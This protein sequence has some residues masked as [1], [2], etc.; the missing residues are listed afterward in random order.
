[1]SLENF[2]IIRDARA[3]RSSSWDR[4]GGN[5]DCLTD[6][7][8]GKSPVILDTDG[9]GKVTH[10]WI[11][12]M[13]FPGHETHFRDMVI[14][15][16]W[17]GSMVPSVEVPIGDFFGLGHA[18][19]APFYAR[20]KYTVVSEPVT[21]GINERAMNCYWPMPFHRSARIEV[22]NNGHQSLRQLYY[23][24]DYELGPQPESTG[25][26]HAVFHQENARA[27]QVTDKHYVNLDGKENYVMLETEGRGHYAGCFFY[28]DTDPGGWWGEGDDMIFIDRSP[29]PTINGTG[30]EDYFNNAWCYHHSFSFPYFGAPLLETRPDGG[31]YTSLYRFH[32]P[33]PIH[34]SEHI[35]VTMECWWENTRTNFISSVAFW[36]QEEPISS[37]APLPVGR[38]NHPRLHP[39][40]PED[41]W[42]LGNPESA[43]ESYVRLYDLEE[44]LLQA[45]IKIRTCA[46]VGPDFLSL[47]G[48]GAGAVIDTEGRDITIPLP[49]PGDGR[50]RIEVKPIYALITGPMQ[51]WINGGSRIEVAQQVLPKEDEGP[52][53][54]IG[55]AESKGGQL[56]LNVSG[57]PLAPLHGI[58]L[59]KL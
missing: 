52:F 14:R 16:Y 32:I 3:R 4:T 21:I 10:I 37:R 13:E 19:T 42:N 5:I 45:S 12:M 36:Y 48:F 26:F 49:V 35:K 2:A 33:D 18:L 20:R 51:M 40:A 24:V 22:Y 43:G 29:L 23:H 8:P 46:T 27:G 34:F 31:V 39:L 47:K 28:V 11:T 57:G 55:E 44:S 17:D 53:L 9:P 56:T 38:A 30:S 1:M 58:R 50:Y 25:L 54:V 6:I 7:A 59:T 41:R 15:M